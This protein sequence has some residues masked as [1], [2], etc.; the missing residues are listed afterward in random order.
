MRYFGGKQR[1]SKQISELINKINTYDKYVEPFCGSCN[2]A[3]KIKIENKILNDKNKYLIE[4]FNAL[5]CGWIPPDVVS[6]DDYKFTKENQDIIPCIAGFIGHACSNSGKYWG[7]YARDSTTRNYAENGKNSILK[8]METL[9]DAN[10]ISR[11]FSSLDFKDCLIYCDPPYKETTPYNKNVVGTFQY[12]EFI[13][14]VRKQSLNNLVLVS[15]YKHNT[16]DGAKIVLEI[17]SKTDMR[18]KNGNRIPTIEVLWTF[19]SDF[20]EKM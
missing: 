8:K 16:P 4:M 2:V 14:W 10:F 3:S 11:D 12:D 19:N 13:E 15:E 5:K 9:M 6:E 1:I 18:D 7:G 20:D 17:E